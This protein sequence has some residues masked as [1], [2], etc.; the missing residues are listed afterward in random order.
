MNFLSNLLIFP[1]AMQET[2]SDI[3]ETHC[4]YHTM[5]GDAGRLQMNYIKPIL[6][7]LLE[8][9]LITRKNCEKAMNACIST[10]NKQ[11]KKS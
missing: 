1:R 6:L 4:T 11:E 3:D 5:Y 9:K 7:E 2:M 10:F 8:K